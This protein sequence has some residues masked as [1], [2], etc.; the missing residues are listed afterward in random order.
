MKTLIHGG[1][2]VA[3]EEGATGS[4]AAARSCSTPTG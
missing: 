1:D 3:Y 2:V 4:C